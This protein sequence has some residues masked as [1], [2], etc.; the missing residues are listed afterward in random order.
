MYDNEKMWW[1]G[2]IHHIF[3]CIDKE[4]LVVLLYK[5]IIPLF[6]SGC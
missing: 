3:S 5:F 6:E 4:L 1:I 2:F